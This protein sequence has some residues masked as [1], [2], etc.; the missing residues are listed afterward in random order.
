MRKKGIQNVI[1]VT[2]QLRKITLWGT[3]GPNSLILEP[4]KRG[5]YAVPFTVLLNTASIKK[6]MEISTCQN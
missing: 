1:K 3:C 2:R 4:N 5:G 6:V